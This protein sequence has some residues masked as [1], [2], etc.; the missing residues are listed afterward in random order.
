MA[1]HDASGQ[2]RMWWIIVLS[3]LSTLY[4]VGAAI[5]FVAL[6]EDDYQP[7]WRSIPGYALVALLWPL[8]ALAALVGFP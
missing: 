5:V 3:A 2:A 7:T 1:D 6:C 8:F 4:L